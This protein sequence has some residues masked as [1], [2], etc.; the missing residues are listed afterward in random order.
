M[1]RHVASLT[2]LFFWLVSGFGFPV[3]DG[4]AAGPDDLAGGMSFQVRGNAALPSPDDDYD[5]LTDDVET[6]GWWNAAGLF[7][8]DPH[9]PDSDNDGLTDGQEKLYD[10]DPLD[11]HSPGIYVEYEDHL[12][13]RQYSAKESYVQPWGWQQYGDQ[14]IS[15]DA[16]V[17]RRGS[18]FSV[19]GPADAIVQVNKSLDS[20]TTLTPVRDACNGRWRI[21][22]P[23][24][25]TVGRYEIALR[26]G[27]WSKKLKLYVIF[28]LPTPTSSFTQAM[29]DT[30]LYDDDPEDLRDEMGILLGDYKYTHADYPDRI[31]PNAWVNAGSAYRFQLQQFEP[32]VFAEHVIGAINGRSNQWSAAQALVARV[33]K[34][35]RFGYPRVL[36]SSWSVLHPGADDRN[37][38]SNIASLLTAFERS[39]GIPARPFFVDWAHATFDHAAEIW[40]NGTWYAARGYVSVEPEGCGWDCD[41]GYRSLQSRYGWGRDRY[42]PWHSGGSGSG[43]T[44]MAAD[45][46]WTWSGTGWSDTPWGHDYR[47]PS[48]DWDAIVRYNWFDTLFV[49]YWSYWGWSREPKVTGS[50]PYAWPAS[51]NLTGDVS[52][53]QPSTEMADDGQAGVAVRGVDDY[54]VDLDRDGYFD[55]LV[56]EVE[57]DPTQAGTY[58]LQAQLGVDR[59][60]PDLMGSGGLI[61]ATVVRA[62]LSE[63][64]NIVQLPFEGLHI[65]GAKVDGPYVLQYLSITDV[66]SPGPD[67]FA[68][69]AVGHWT[70]LYITGSYRAYD[71]QNRGAAL[72][73]EI[74]ERGL[75][76]DGDTLYESL[77]LD[78][79]LNVLEPGTYT[80]QGDLYDSQERFVARATWSGT[81]STAVLQFDG[82]SDAVGPYTLQEMSLLNADGELIDLLVGA[83]TTQQ[84]FQADGG[85]HIVE[86]TESGEVGLQGILPGPY[87]D[88]GLDLDGDG[89]YDLLEVDVQVEVEEAGQYRLEGWMGG[90]G[91]SL[92]SW[93]AGDPISVT[94]VG[95][96]TLSLA[97]SG[98]AISA[99]N[100][101]G[102]FT[103]IA[104]KLLR[105]DGYEVVDEVDVAYTT[106]SAYTPDQFERLP[107]LELPADYVIL[108]EDHM[109]DG[110]GAW[111]TDWPWALTAAQSHSPTHAW[112]DS[113]GGN[114]ANNRNVSLTTGPMDL[115][116][117]SRPMLQFQ[118][119]YDL[120]TDYDYGYV[121]ISTDGGAT[122]YSVSTYTGR[123]AHWTGEMVDLGMI[124]GTETLRVRFHLDTDAGVTADGWYIDDVAIYFD[125]DQ[126][127]D[128]IPDSIEVGDDASEP[129]D[130]DGDGKPDYLDGDSDNDG[131]PDSIEAG[132]DPTEPVDTDRDGIPDYVDGDSDN[133]GFPDG[134]EGTG[135]HD[136]DGIPN[137]VD[138]E[139]RVFLPLV[140]R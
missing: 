114:Y 90:G 11:G 10:A 50:P 15:L 32:F 112:T 9:D 34:V 79:G 70:S 73:G 19:G 60:V 17:V 75:D 6:N 59:Q 5:G 123:M 26:D 120:E 14:L 25:S 13:T 110:E 44:V 92:I 78:V 72:S 23:S 68:N 126:D 109:E 86:R 58:W 38:C 33:D 36:A 8:T 77:I 128:G 94:T 121:E 24:G 117:F 104:L 51:A 21:Y 62:D 12:K 80:V 63:G 103:L 130:T 116:A 35:T 127:D 107:Y 129:V 55:Q 122:W 134:E 46:N 39:A 40:L 29:I 93:A 139:V 133:D 4:T 56:I 2:V 138:F 42:R 74:S 113:P 115:V 27:E 41:Y 49:P 100:T 89:L 118:T 53:E 137:Y 48:W 22:V 108:F 7:T 140:R 105:G 95:T 83:Y 47:W 125:K 82:L 3:E 99:H 132:D 91:G 43:S 28:E 102:P 37:Q 20:L 97:F 84:G 65:S 45:E 18:T 69:D 88:S 64:T 96:Y 52:S 106:A 85:T 67:E 124:G 16:V 119:C 87:T 30:F 98:P 54:A 1:K 71:F 101:D 57:V 61:A 76:A 131:I 31:P 135:D 66:D 111:T 81:G 136:G